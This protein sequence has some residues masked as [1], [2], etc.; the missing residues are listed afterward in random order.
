VASGSVLSAIGSGSSPFYGDIT[1]DVNKVNSTGGSGGYSTVGVAGFN[2]TQFAV[3]VGD[4]L[5]PG[6]VFVKAGVI[7]AGTLDTYDSS[8]FL[9]PSNLT[10]AVPVNKGGT[11]LTTYATG[12]IIF[13]TGATT[14]NKLNI[15]VADNVLTST[16]TA[17]QWSSGL[18]I[19]RRLS[20]S[21][22]EIFTASTSGATVFNENAKAIDIGGAATS[23]VIGSNSATE[24]LTAN[25]KSY[26]T[27]G[28]SSTSVTAQIGL[29]ATIGTIARN[30]SN[31]ATIATIV[32]HGLTNGDLVTVV[33]STDGSFNTV[34]SAAT[35]VNATTFTYSN[36]GATVGT[37]ASSGTV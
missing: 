22:A 15:D 34:N 32:N 21:S 2:T 24:S 19:P 14:L 11:F 17:P 36:T 12:D 33:C 8:Y 35:V 27:S 37:T 1:I 5:N 4:S 31:V 29:P 23:V 18:T 30:G 16:G 25:V 3:G 20:T 6:E 28:S 26:T 10:S 7:D 9:N 13:A